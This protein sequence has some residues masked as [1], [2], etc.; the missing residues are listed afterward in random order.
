MI[1][2]RGMRTA[3]TGATAP[4]RTPMPPATGVQLKVSIGNTPGG[5]ASHPARA[6][7]G[8]YGAAA[9]RGAAARGTATPWSALP[10]AGRIQPSFGRHDISSI[11]AHV[12]DAAAASAAEIGA[13]AYATANHVV[14]GKGSDLFTVA[15]EAAHVIQQRAGVQLRG[16]VGT[17]GDPHEQHADAVAARVTAGQ[18]AE[19]LL[20][21]YAGQSADRP[22][23]RSPAV[24]SGSE[25]QCKTRIVD[26]PGDLQNQVA[27]GSGAGLLQDSEGNVHG[28]DEFVF[29]P[30]H[31]DCGTFMEAH[32]DPDDYDDAGT[33]PQTGSWPNWWA[34]AAPNP[35]NYW[36]RGH[37][38]N[39][40][41]G[42]PGEKRN[43][44]PIT[45]KANHEH[46]DNVEKFVK[47]AA[48]AGDSQ[49]SYSVRAIYDGY[50]PQGLIANNTN[51]D[52]SVWHMLTV[53]F[54]C[55]F[56][57]IDEQGND[58]LFRTFVKNER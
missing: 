57:I 58:R 24:C 29:G 20:D 35:N 14:L 50:G 16:G 47:M 38:L 15:H 54:D 7:G 51:P 25:I 31:N 2:H 32:I 44:T 13:D 53:G 49:I 34:A 56:F 9:V 48:Q 28:E 37:L 43:L 11:Q 5:L 23:R 3:M 21:A 19:A 12:G 52:P 27:P 18:S 22:Q 36:V 10:H 4:T 40:N 45:K 33:V 55:G 42:G 1:G 17:A 8:Q 41:V 39:H 30:L 6:H 46:H 26:H